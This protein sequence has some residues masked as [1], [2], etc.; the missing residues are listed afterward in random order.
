[1]QYFD[2]LTSHQW[3][4]SGDKAWYFVTTVR[5]SAPHTAIVIA[6]K[7]MADFFDS[8]GRFVLSTSVHGCAPAGEY[9][10]FV[11]KYVGQFIDEATCR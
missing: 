4:G 1:M 9:R 5:A 11:G 10:R 7:R 3:L 2:V 6:R 8:N